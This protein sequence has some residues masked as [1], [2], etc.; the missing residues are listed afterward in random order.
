MFN[1]QV[2]LM[3]DRTVKFYPKGRY[4]SIDPSKAG[5]YMY[6]ADRLTNCNSTRLLAMVFIVIYLAYR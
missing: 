1:S 5:L 2:S 3:T 4:Y 6:M